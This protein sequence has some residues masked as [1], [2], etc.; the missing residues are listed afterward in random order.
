MNRTLKQLAATCSLLG[1][2]ATALA[3]PAV[4]RDKVMTIDS[5]VLI[6]G[7]IQNYYSD[8]VLNTDANG[9]LTIVSANQL[10]LVHVDD[11]SSLVTENSN[12]R[13][14]SIAVT[15]YKSV[16]CVSLA[17][18]AVSYK[19]RVFTVVLAET[20]M[21]PA[22]SCI[23]II[24]PFETDVALDVTDLEAGTYDVVVNGEHTSFTLA[25]DPLQ[26]AD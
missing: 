4:Y 23:A 26:I 17:D 12:E 16:P 15:G 19:N 21:G 22:E 20:L 25:S 10:P 24:D 9:K 2:A 6:N 1:L 3:D 5:G 14:V 18:A 7:S 8:I 13:S 11:V